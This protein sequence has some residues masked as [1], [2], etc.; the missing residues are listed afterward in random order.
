MTSE[1]D[2]D[3]YPI[4]RRLR[5]RG[6]ACITTTSSAS[7]LVS[8]YED[9]RRGLADAKRHNSGRGGILELIKANI[10]MPP[11]TL[12][13]E[14]PPAAHRPPGA[15]VAGIHSSAGGRSRTEHPGVLL[16]QP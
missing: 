13:F 2:A 15:A 12:I 6:T 10:D 7:T 8:R 14:D 16:P 5:D 4:Y 11:G 1:I 3:P 9:C